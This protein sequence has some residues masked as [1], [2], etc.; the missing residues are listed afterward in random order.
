MEHYVLMYEDGEFDMDNEYHLEQLCDVL[1]SMSKTGTKPYSLKEC[2]EIAKE[3][4]VKIFTI[5]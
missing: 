3:V 4:G 1:C 5:S 2:Q